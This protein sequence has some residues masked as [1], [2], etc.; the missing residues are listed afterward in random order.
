[1]YAFQDFFYQYNYLN[2]DS[3]LSAAEQSVLNMNDLRLGCLTFQEWHRLP[4]TGSGQCA[5]SLKNKHFLMREFDCFKLQVTVKQGLLFSSSKNLVVACL[6][7]QVSM[8][9]LTTLQVMWSTEIFQEIGVILYMVSFI[10][11]NK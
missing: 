9:L 11:L 10:R 8:T 7:S 6:T 1:M 5:L 3:K 4:M 2:N